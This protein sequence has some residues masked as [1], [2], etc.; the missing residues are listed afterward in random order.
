VRPSVE[1]L[2]AARRLRRHPAFTLTS[3]MTLGVGIGASLAMFAVVHGVVL[4]PLPYPESSRLVE[5][6]HSAPGI[7]SEGGL[8]MTQGLYLLYR[9]TSRALDGLAVHSDADVTLTGRGEPRRLTATVTTHEVAAVLG[10]QPALGSFLVAQD[11]E[12]GAAPVTVLSHRLW[13]SAF[14]AD[15][16]VVGS[17]VVLNGV[18]VQVIGVMPQSFGFP[19]RDTDVWL[20]R[21][22]N[23]DTDTF[24]SFTLR[25]VARLADGVDAEAARDELQGLIPRL[26]ERFPGPTSREVVESARLTA[27]VAPLKESIVGD[28]TTTLWVLLGT[29][30]LVLL[31]AGVN[32]ANLLV[33]RMEG[34][35]REM[36]VRT[37]LGAGPR[38]IA[39]YVLAETAW[40]AVVSG[41]IG[42]ALAAVA[43]G[44]V[45]RFG[46]AGLPRLEEI[47][48][49]PAVWA[50]AFALSAGAG[51]VLGTI[52]LL[53]RR[54]DLG[55][56]LK[57]GARSTADRVRLR[58]RNALVVSQTAFALI[59]IVGAG[60]MTRSFWHLS[61]VDPGFDADGVLTFQIS[62]P[63]TTYPTRQ[64]AVAFH[65][66]L[67][68][69]LR[70]L[71]GVERVGA[72]T[73]LP[74]CGSWAGN[75]WARQ[76]Q[77]PRDGEIPPIVAT[78][79]VSEGYLEAMRIGLLRGRT[80]ERRD[81]EQLTGAAVLN[82]QAADKLFPAEDPIGRRIYPTTE[83]DDPPWY[84]VVGIVE[85]APVTSLTDDPAPVVYLPLAHRDASGI[86]PRLL[87]Y[88]VR[89]TLP[90][91]SL[92]EAVQREVRQLDAALPLAYVRTMAGIVRE[93]G[94]RMAFT[95]VLLVLAA[96]MALFLATVGIYSVIAYMVSQRTAEFGIRLAIGA[97]GE[98]LTLLVL[99]QGGVPVG[100]GL[101]IGLLG[102]AALTRFMRAMVFGVTTT[103]P[104]TYAIV[105]MLLVAVALLAILGPARRAA[106]VDA[107]ESL[108]AE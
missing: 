108:R 85:N 34:R 33:V 2:S 37:A 69:R 45:R 84:Q 57:E 91:L 4:N 105:T 48:V 104:L 44:L 12:P 9:E 32:A 46:P 28:V 43:L 54:L 15:P 66:A 22:V 98:D 81:H 93:A 40:L 35:Q 73:C 19:S 10:V 107:M 86:N 25:G 96:S 100:M 51:L 21:T 106:T 6:D 60:L 8:Q 5:V 65:D 17:S 71:H 77:P 61:R 14:G 13:T 79:R 94:A 89:T 36:A 78:R 87:V 38:K 99:R 75:P 97:R 27:L 76:D 50:A 95:M 59:L 82:R 42:I 80:I 88:T 18:G 74:L 29:V 56:V 68:A 83:P 102:A 11:G 72:T 24:G 49:S 58:A 55:S 53:G 70:A 26:I 103:D 64:S 30:A 47:G 1:L 41:A 90:P 62:L 31:I 67:L 3:L 16:A 52:P 92:V 20:A 101:V 39:A 7:G 23:P 63:P